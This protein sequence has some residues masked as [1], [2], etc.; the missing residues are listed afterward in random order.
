MLINPISTVNSAN[1][2]A[3][4]LPTQCLRESFD[5]IEKN[6]DSAI[7]KDLNYAKDFI[8]SL[9]AISESKKIKEFRIEIDKR[10]SQH[11]Y[12]KINGS[13]VSG[14]YN[15]NIPNLLDSYLIAEGVKRYASKLEDF[16]PSILDSLKEQ[17]E[18][19]QLVLDELKERY[20]ERL[21]A[22]FEQAKK[23]IF[24]DAK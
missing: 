15:G 20:S 7:M 1:F 13:R 5:R 17:V 3:N 11:T 21:K 16:K 12:T 14:G 6:T 19:A 10:R 24:D 18:E 4:I 8:D 2:R 23:I 9:A 22:E